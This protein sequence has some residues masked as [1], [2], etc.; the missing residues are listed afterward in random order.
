MDYF[1]ILEEILEFTYVGHGNTIFLFKCH[2]FDPRAVRRDLD[3]DIV[4]V[5]HK[6]KLNTYEPFILA[7]QAQQ[8]YYTRYASTRKKELNEWWA[9]CKVKSRLYPTE[10]EEVEV[11][12]QVDTEYFQSEE[13]PLYPSGSV[14]ALDPYD[15][16][17]HSDGT[18]FEEIN[19]A[20][21]S[22]SRCPEI[23]NEEVEEE[24]EEKEEEE[25]NELGEE[26][27]SS[28]E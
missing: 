18:I 23:G 2:W 11:V 19:V 28:E 5:K 10:L 4:D 17:E 27:S 21:V 15:H 13:L 14:T 3:Y 6:S 1:G 8:V 12:G 25:E 22:M 16:I 9:V 20:D 26:F 7:Q 24:D